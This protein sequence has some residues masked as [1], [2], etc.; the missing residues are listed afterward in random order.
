MKKDLEFL[1]NK[2]VAHR[3]YHD[4][5]IGIPE[6]SI[7]AF[8]RAIEKNYLIEFDL[9]LLKDGNVV[10]FHDDNLKRM[11]GLDSPIKDKTYK[12]LQNLKLL[13]T[14][15]HIPLF[16]DILKLINGK[17]PI[18]I[19]LKFDNKCGLLEDKV[20]NT[21]K[22]Y[23]GKYAIKSF[24]PLTVNYLRKKAPNVIRGQ[25]SS[26]FKTDNINILKKKFMQSMLYNIIT[27]PDF[28]SYDIRALPSKRLKKL[29]K[30]KLIMAWTIKDKTSFM[31]A[32][33]NCD[34]FIMENIEDIIEPKNSQNIYPNK[35]SKSSRKIKNRKNDNK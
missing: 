13:N 6:N 16:S 21:L 24:N 1:K 23:K 26:D 25:L 2:I 31:V 20:L 14:N 12:E 10:V 7:P 19:E 27:K 22:D 8:K 33:N 11:T 4:I 35:S 28:I 17:V 29:R 15:E 30:N 34:T 32:Q 5:N 3:G 9:H 18:I